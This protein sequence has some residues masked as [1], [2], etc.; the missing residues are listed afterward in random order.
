MLALRILHVIG[1]VAWIGGGVAAALAMALLAS[2]ADTT[3]LAAARALRK[4]VLWLVTPG[5]L[6]SL[7][8]GVAMLLNDW[9]VLYAK[10]PWMHAKLTVGLVAAA[11]SGVLSGRLRRGSNDAAALTPGVFRNAG[12]VLLLSGIANVCFVFLRFGAH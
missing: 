10:A 9:A 3:R 4:V 2:E 1:N 12:L 7:A 11:F 5:M 8:A 6:L